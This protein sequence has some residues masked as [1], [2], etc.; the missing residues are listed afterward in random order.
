MQ[1]PYQQQPPQG[2]Q[3]PQLPSMN[4]SLF[5]DQS[6]NRIDFSGN[7]SITRE[8]AMALCDYLLSQRA[9]G[10]QYGLKLFISGWRKQSRQ[11][12]NYISLQ[13]QPPRN[14]YLGIAPQQQAQPQPVWN[15]QT[16][17]WVYPQP[18]APVAA[19][20]PQPAPPPAPPAPPAPG[21]PVWDPQA[22]QWVH[23]QPLAPAAPPAAPVAPP[24]P[25]YGQGGSPGQPY[26]NAALVGAAV[27]AGAPMPGLSA[28]AQPSP[29][30]VWASGAPM[31]TDAEIPF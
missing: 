30:P 24:A 28:A 23:P 4:G 2:Q 16:G 25:P 13:I 19:P 10:D 29:P 3:Q 18:P 8:D 22:G 5:T 27:H 9:E 1:A 7:C 12:K 21:Q 14:A 17:Q 6:Q 15:P 26:S 20:A 11:G 31:P